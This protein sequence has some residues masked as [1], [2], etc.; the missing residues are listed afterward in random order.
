[1]TVLIVDDE[2]DF[3]DS[4]RDAF[5]DVGYQ[6]ATAANGTDAMA[7]LDELGRV[8]VV[9]LDLVMPWMTGGEVYDAMRADPRFADIPVIVATSDATRAP[10]GVKTMLK[11]L[12][13]GE[14]LTEV[15]K[16]CRPG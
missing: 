13:L 14:L 15:A 12:D 10:P 8:C 5:E 1:M 7:R 2:A 9:I 4:L 11:P 16:H 3:R 6:V